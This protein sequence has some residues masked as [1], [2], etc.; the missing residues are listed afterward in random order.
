MDASAELNDERV[1]KKVI[2][3]KTFLSK[4]EVRYLG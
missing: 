1:K 2:L 3:E 4:A